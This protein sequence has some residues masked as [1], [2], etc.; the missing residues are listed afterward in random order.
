MWIPEKFKIVP[1]A[2]DLPLTANPTMP[3]SINMS[4]YHRAT[5]IIQTHTLGGGDPVLTCLSGAADAT[6][7][8]TLYFKYAYAGSAVLGTTADVLAADS[9]LVN[10]LTIAH[11]TYDN[12]MLIVEVNADDMDMANQ[13]EWLTL[14]FADAGATT[15][16]VTIV[17]ILEPRYTQARS[18]TALA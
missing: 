3:D 9:A 4:K 2:N 14:N 16:N 17:A 11:A 6:K 5:F 8:S 7:T 15:G 18:V 13:E 10:T 12:W 1:I